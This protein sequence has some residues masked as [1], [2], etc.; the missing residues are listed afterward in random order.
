MR[1]CTKLGFLSKTLLRS[2]ITIELLERSYWHKGTVEMKSK[3][4]L[5]N[6]QH[7]SLDCRAVPIYS[8]WS[9]NCL[10]AKSILAI[11]IGQVALTEFEFVAREI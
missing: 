2:N 9:L 7:W 4:S 3:W 1:G 5:S 8:L 6:G 10:I 11:F